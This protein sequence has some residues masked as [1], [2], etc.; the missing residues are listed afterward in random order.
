LDV[1]KVFRNLKTYFGDQFFLALIL[2]IQRDAGTQ[3]GPALRC[4]CEFMH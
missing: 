2:D 4:D 3:K 1:F